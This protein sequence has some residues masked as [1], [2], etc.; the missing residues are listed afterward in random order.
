M[1]PE[2]K[3]LRLAGLCGIAAPILALLFIFAAIFFSPWF[4]W[5]ANALSD[6][7]VGEAALIFNFG[8]V[9]GG[10]LAAV[11]AVGLFLTYQDILRRLGV[12]VFFLGT[13]SLIGIGIFSEAAG[14]IHFYF[15]V[16]FFVLVPLSLWIMGAGI[17][18][19]GSKGFGVLTM[20][21]AVM[22]TLPWVGQWT[23]VAVPELL[24]SLSFAVWSIIQGVRF[25]FGGL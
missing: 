15:S 25:Y 13:L 2:Y 3:R 24:S 7:G 10:I 22:G 11:F 18:R 16:A 6:L 14:R 5:S 20:I 19:S 8:L 9:I 1:T 23:A 21:I 12:L 4:H 17:F